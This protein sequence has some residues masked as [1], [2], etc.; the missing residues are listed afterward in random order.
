M[1]FLNTKHF[2]EISN[3]QELNSLDESLG[4]AIRYH[5]ESKIYYGQSKQV[6][7]ITLFKREGWLAIPV[8]DPDFFTQTFQQQLYEALIS[9]KYFNL[10]VLLLGSKSFVGYSGSPTLD[11][12]WELRFEMGSYCS[13]LFAGVP[14]P[15]F[16]IISIESDYYVVAGKADFIHQIFG[17]ELQAHFFQFQDFAMSEGPEFFKKHLSLLC[18]QLKDEYEKAEVGAEFHI[19]PYHITP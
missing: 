14:E 6:L 9:H 15:D 2:Q 10:Y 19:T 7:E 17:S 12:L 16:A 4:C 11:S 13:V 1:P 3:I 8:P 18:N 5:G